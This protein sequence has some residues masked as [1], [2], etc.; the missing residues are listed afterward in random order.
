MD[1]RNSK[2]SKALII[3]A[4]I[5]AFTGLGAAYMLLR[6]ADKNESEVSLSTGE[7]LRLGFIVLGL[8]RSIMQLGEDE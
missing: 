3:G 4:L 2:N 5:G 6:R 7:G 8:L 1:N